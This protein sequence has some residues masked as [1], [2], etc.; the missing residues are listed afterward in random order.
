MKMSDD[1]LD[2][3]IKEKLCNEISYIPQD[4]D[5]VFD[6]TINKLR[7][8]RKIKF[9]SVAGI[10]VA[11]LTIFIILGSSITT[12]ASNIPIIS[13]I[14]EMF[15]S[16]RYEN[17]DKYASDLNITK[18]SNGI[19]TTI[20]KVV[21]D[22]IELSIFY[23]IESEE[24]MNEIPYFLV[25]D[26]KIND[27]VTTFVYGTE[28][29]FLDNNKT[30]SGVISYDVGINSVVP[31]EDQE[32]DLYGG[33]VEIPD[34]FLLSIEVR[35]IGDIKESKVIDGSWVFN[36]P[37]SNEKLKGMVKEYDLNKDLSS[38][39]EGSKA[40]KLILTPINTTIQGY[41]AEDCDLYFTV[42]DDKGRFISEKLG[43]GS[44]SFN[45]E[46][47]EVFYFNYNYKEIFEDTKSLTF[48]P[49]ERNYYKLPKD[50]NL[51]GNNV[52]EDY[53]M[54]SKLNLN[55]ETVLKS[56]DGKDY[57]TITRVETSDEKTRL[58]FKS[59]Y[60]ILAAPKKIINNATNEEI[61]TIDNI[62][63][64]DINVS[65]Y[66]SETGEYMI[67]FNGQLTSEDCKIQYYDISEKVTVYNN[68]LF[69]V[70][71]DK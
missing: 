3:K 7:N 23:M 25:K 4:I 13:S 61:T 26:I 65:R 50:S 66:L 57:I 51:P 22:G 34:E 16:N 21:Y 1:S 35:E 69:T 10:C 41:I 9:K 40:S 28:G 17:Y 67:E 71:L 49:Y 29:R 31:K 24:P 8:N 39:Y 46:N 56:K 44:G 36:I 14:L 53:N 54:S 5:K 58:Y 60:G 38:V 20:T 63:S 30:Y 18:E 11:L 12:Y 37:V 2:K 52:K 59:D 42:I 19:K 62:N 43:G 55:G 70:K 32:K 47:K 15:K 6:K 33:Y 45:H 27:N 64:E 68:G 48:I